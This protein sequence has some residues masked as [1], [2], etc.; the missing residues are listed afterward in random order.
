M[1]HKGI[2]PGNN[3]EDKIFLLSGKEAENLLSPEKMKTFMTE[4]ADPDQE[5]YIGNYCYWWLRTPGW[6]NQNFAMYF[7]NDANCSGRIVCPQDLDV[8]VRP[9]MWIDLR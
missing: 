8:Y 3:T 2:T 9:T 1:S 5:K 7:A 4:Y 6:T